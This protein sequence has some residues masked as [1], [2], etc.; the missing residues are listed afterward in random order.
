[1]TLVTVD[2]GTSKR[3][4]REKTK[5]TETKT[6]TQIPSTITT[7]QDPVADLAT[8]AALA[9]ASASEREE[10]RTVHED[11]TESPGAST[12]IFVKVAPGPIQAPGLK[13]LV[14]RA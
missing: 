4:A 1:M 7:G 10:K 9:E 14:V 3:R 2:P 12:T 8:F 6:G 13:S 5:G 11:V